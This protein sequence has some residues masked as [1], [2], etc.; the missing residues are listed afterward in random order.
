MLQEAL[1]RQFVATLA[2]RMD[3]KKARSPKTAAGRKSEEEVFRRRILSPDVKLVITDSQA[4]DVVDGW[5]RDPLTGKE[6]VPLTTFS[7]AMANYLSGGRL[8]TFAAGLKTFENL[9][10]G[11]AVLICEGCNH[12]RIIDDIG[13]T[14][15]PRAI[16]R[17]FGKGANKVDHAFGREYEKVDL[18]KYKLAIHV[19]H[20]FFFF[21]SLSFFDSHSTL[22][23]WP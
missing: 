16:E 6:L 8:R 7:V 20:F 18:N 13:I 15:I 12:N 5:T 17:R 19:S 2:H 22:I 4:M 9:K 14:Q 10:S 1:L 23:N 11:D 3:L 21:F